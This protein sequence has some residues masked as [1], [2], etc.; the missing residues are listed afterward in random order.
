[1]NGSRSTV[2]KLFCKIH[3]K[4]VHVNVEEDFRK[5]L[6]EDIELAELCFREKNLLCVISGLAVLV[7]KLQT[8]VLFSPCHHPDIKMLLVSIHHLQHI[9]SKLPI[10]IIGPPGP[11]GPS[12]P[13]GPT[14][15]QGPPGPSGPQ[16]PQGPKGA[17]GTTSVITT[18]SHYRQP[19]PS[20]PPPKRPY[21][22]YST[23]IV[24]SKK[25]P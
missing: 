21:R 20:C 8:Y 22:D 6:L 2:E 19:V 13:P 14:G 12:G 7:G 23:H 11:V 1:M 9:L 17:S 24:C 3:H 25:A 15:P 5:L 18:T 4:I 10:C 16:G